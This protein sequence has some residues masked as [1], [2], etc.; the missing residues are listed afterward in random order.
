MTCR[1]WL[2]KVSFALQGRREAAQ[3]QSTGAQAKPSAIYND[4]LASAADLIQRE[5]RAYTLHLHPHCSPLNNDNPVPFVPTLT[6]Y[7]AHTNLPHTNLLGRRPQPRACP[8]A[9]SGTAPPCW[10]P[11]MHRG[12]CANISIQAQQDLGSFQ[13][14]PCSSI[15]PPDESRSCTRC[16]LIADVSVSANRI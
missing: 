11:P 5:S 12:T 16:V 9:Q 3:L 8:S 14:H 6:L 13:D 7:S 10:P 1:A 2:K 15:Q 4:R